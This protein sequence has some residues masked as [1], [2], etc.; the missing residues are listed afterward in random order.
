[1]T[2]KEFLQNNPGDVEK[3]KKCKNI[4][5]FKNLIKSV[6]ISYNSEK[7]LVEAYD[8]VKG[9]KAALSDDALEAAS[10]GKGRVYSASEVYKRA[11]GGAIITDGTGKKH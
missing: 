10:G 5:E 8:F 4:D 6:G 1:M 11:D 7:E 9:N 3:A 2:F